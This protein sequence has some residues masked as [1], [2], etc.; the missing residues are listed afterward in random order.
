MNYEING[1]L[2]VVSPDTFSLMTNADLKK[3]FG[4]TENRWGIRDEKRHMIISCGW[5]RQGDMMNYLSD[6][7]SIANGVRQRMKKNLT[8]FRASGFFQEKRGI[9][10]A[11]GFD[12]QFRAVNDGCIYSGKALVIKHCKHFYGF[13][14]YSSKENYAECARI[15]EDLFLSLRGL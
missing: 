13:I 15:F 14:Y 2:T 7:R 11:K 10:K 9:H 6:E 5:T 12:F 3:F 8:D 4:S 1:E